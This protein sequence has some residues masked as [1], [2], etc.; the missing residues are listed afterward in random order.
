MKIKTFTVIAAVLLAASSAYASPGFAPYPYKAISAFLNFPSNVSD[1]HS[2]CDSATEYI[3][4]VSILECNNAEAGARAKLNEM[5][6]ESS[7]NERAVYWTK[8]FEHAGLSSEILPLKS[9]YIAAHM[10][11]RYTVEACPAPI[12][13]D[14]AGAW[15]CI[16]AIDNAAWLHADSWSEAYPPYIN[17]E[18]WND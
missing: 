13:R 2:L 11:I 16:E 7:A 14:S 9:S 5:L 15:A 3:P 4:S 17:Q 6:R 8:C 10:C 1:A 12:E 18:Q